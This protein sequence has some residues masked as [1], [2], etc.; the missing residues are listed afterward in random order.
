MIESQCGRV[1]M[2][3]LKNNFVV[4]IT[5]LFLSIPIDLYSKKAVK[6]AVSDHSQTTSKF[7][8]SMF[9]SDSQNKAL[10]HLFFSTMPK[11]GDIHHHYSGSLY[12]ET[13]LEWV[14]KKGWFIDKCTLNII[15]KPQKNSCELLSVKE[16]MSNAKLYR[17]LLSLWSD[18]DYGKY[19][20]RQPPPDSNFFNTFLYFETVSYEYIP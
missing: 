19:I 2:Q 8:E 12:A 15:K 20:H 4:F 16:L 18:K 9:N 13:Y 3:Y 5:I 10:L 14:S 1:I 6:T 17:K 11:G 7:Y